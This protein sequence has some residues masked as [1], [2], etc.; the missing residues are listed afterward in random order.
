[1]G[2]FS[3]VGKGE[4][5]CFS[6]CFFCFCECLWSITV[7]FLDTYFEYDIDGCKYYN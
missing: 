6:K 2:K 1:L 4:V 3:I 5:F 7:F